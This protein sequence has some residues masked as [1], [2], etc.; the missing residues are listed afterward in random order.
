MSMVMLGLLFFASFVLLLWGCAWFGA[1]ILGPH[2]RTELPHPGVR[3]PVLPLLVSTAWFLIAD[4]DSPRGGVIHVH[5]DN[6]VS[7]AAALR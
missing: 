1:A 3:L 5:P 6:L 7:L 4:I 2:G